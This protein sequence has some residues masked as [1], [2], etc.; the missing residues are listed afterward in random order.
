MLSPDNYIQAPDFSQSFNRYS[1]AWNNPLVFTDP[2]GE[3][4][5]AAIIVG[6]IVGAY[7]GGAAAEGWE[8]NPGKWAWDGDTW[9]GIG[10]GVMIGGAAG[11]G[12][13]YAA[14]AL[15]NAGF[16]AHFGASGKVAAYTLTSGV[17]G[18]AV[19]YGAGFSGGMLYSNGNWGYSHQSGIL[20]AKVGANVGSVIGVISGNIA[21]YEPPKLL[22]PIQMPDKPKWDG[23][24]YQGTEEDA[25]EILLSSSKM[26]NVEMSY[27]STSK[28][29]Y[30]EPIQGNAYGYYYDPTTL[31]LTDYNVDV[32]YTSNT[33]STTYRY[34]YVENL[35]G[36]LYLSPNIFQRS[37]VYYKAH[38]HPRSSPPSGADLLFSYLFGIRSI[39][40][41]WNGAVYNYGGSG[42]W[43]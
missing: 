29:Y 15:A 43:K 34:T 9:A 5:I 30:F 24:Y 7:I 4:I 12:F 31:T 22:S 1:Y 33:I 39:V 23:L 27:W 10:L 18:G 37:M 38:T 40:F 17:A 25:K 21:A 42:Y 3:F 32:G 19:G 41:G 20:G 14:P 8:Y 36:N 16:F 6:A 35:G 11:V 26:F 13:Y 2:D 28:G